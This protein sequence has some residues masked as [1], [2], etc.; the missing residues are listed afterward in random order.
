MEF[1]SIKEIDERSKKLLERI[2]IYTSIILRGKGFVKMMNIPTL[3]YDYVYIHCR[4]VRGYQVKEIYAEY[5]HLYISRTKNGCIQLSRVAQ[6]CTASIISDNYDELVKWLDDE[7][8]HYPK[9]R[10]E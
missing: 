10:G 3:R 2:E 4:L 8:K 1:E 6:V 9:L 7:F 5:P